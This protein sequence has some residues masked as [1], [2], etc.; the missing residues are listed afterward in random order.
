MTDAGFH[1]PWFKAVSKL[2]WC[3]IGRLRGRNRVLLQFDPFWR[4]ARASYRRATSKALVPG[5]GRYA[6]SNPVNVRV[7]LAKRQ[8]K[9]RWQLT[10]FGARAA[11]RK[12]EKNARR[13]REPWLLATSP[14]LSH[15]A[16]KSIVARYRQR[17]GIEQSFRNNKHLRVGMG[18][19]LARS[20]SAQ[21]LNILLLIL[22]LAA[23]KQRLIGDSAKE[24]Q[25][26]LQFS[27]TR[28][29]DRREVSVL[30]LVRRI[31]DEPP[32]LL[33]QLRPIQAIAALGEQAIDA[34]AIAI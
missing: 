16:V 34:Y 8:D 11:S 14:A 30:T 3:Y 7:V 28:R 22:H 31:L 13:A 19:E 17:M 26:E 18:F 10:I 33:K 12:S 20:R 24:S 1:A 25:L 6:Y 5:A 27:A 23:F 9:Q 15:L 21:H 4:P 2:G 29:K 32:H